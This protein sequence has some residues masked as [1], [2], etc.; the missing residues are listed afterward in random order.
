MADVIVVDVDVDVVVTVAPPAT[1][2]PTTTVSCPDRNADSER[3]DSARRVVTWRR[4]VN[5]RI[6]VYG[7]SVNHHGAIRGH[8]HHLWVGLLDDDNGLLFNNLCF[9]FICSLDFKFPAFFAFMRMRWTASITSDCC[10]RKAFP[11]SVVQVMSS[12]RRLTTSGSTAM[13]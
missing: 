13:A 11:R 8:V 7:R 12:A 9:Y 1:V 6:R 4:I 10:A 2:A 5:R 3:E